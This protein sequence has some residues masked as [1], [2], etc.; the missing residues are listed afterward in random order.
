MLLC[1]QN[2]AIPVTLLVEKGI[3]GV[4]ETRSYASQ[5]SL[6]LIADPRIT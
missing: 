5:V 2:S 6:K 1:S 3:D 4:F